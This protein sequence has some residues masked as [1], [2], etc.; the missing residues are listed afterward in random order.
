MFRNSY[1]EGFLTIFYSIGS[2]PLAI[3]RQEIKNG[4]MKRI[5]DEDIKSMALEIMGT[6]VST[7]FV[8]A[9]RDPKMSLA[10]KLPFLVLL[11][12]NMRKLFTFE[13]QI[14]DDQKFL[15]RFR[16]SNYESKTRVKT[17]CMSMPMGLSPGWNQI[18]LNLADFTR[19]AYG[20]NY[21]ETVRVQI[22]ANI[23][24]RRI[25]F[26]DKLY[27]EEDLP[28]EYKIMMFKDKKVDPK[29]APPPK[30]RPPSP[31]TSSNPV[32]VNNTVFVEASN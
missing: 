20:T 13:V 14:L 12:K 21:I 28:N 16:I 2:K 9:P 24:I 31:E 6:N 4:H 25:Y 7:T 19:R 1:Q 17:F 11:L 15:R 27:A 5:V 18:H 26:T 10:I 32:P 8:A 29:K 22:H 3:W 30:A 23:R